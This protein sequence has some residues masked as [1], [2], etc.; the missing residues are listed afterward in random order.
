[1]HLYLKDYVTLTSLACGVVSMIFAI[2]GHLQFACLFVWLAFVFD[3]FDGV[4]ARLTKKK[5]AI[6]GHLDNTV[7][8]IGCAVAPSLCVY[9]GYKPLLGTYGAAALAAVPTIFG[10]IRHA[11]NYANPPRVQNL[12]VGLPRTYSGM[13][14]AGLLGSHIFVYPEVQYAGIGLIIFLPFLGITAVPYQGRHHAGLRWYQTGCLV[15]TALTMIFGIVWALLGYGLE[16]FFDGLLG[17]MLGY[18]L[19]GWIG[20]I[21]EQ[22]RQ[23]YTRYIKEWKK[24]FEEQT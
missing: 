14:I 7:D 4:V 5:N 22:E 11:R 9:V 13:A 18:V 6:G 23:E 15:L 20:E 10:A 21:P 1:M 24:G 12:W 8:F 2:E 16:T 17:W 19:L 3:A